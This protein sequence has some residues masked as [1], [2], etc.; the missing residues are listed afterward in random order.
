MGHAFVPERPHGTG[1]GRAAP[2]AASVRFIAFFCRK[3]RFHAGRSPILP[4]I[5]NFSKHGA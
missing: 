2:D 1:M 3:A 4:M 5:Y